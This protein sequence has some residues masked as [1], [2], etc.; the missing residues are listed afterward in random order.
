MFYKTMAEPI[1]ISLACHSP[2]LNSTLNSLGVRA[3]VIVYDKPEGVEI[4]SYM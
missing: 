4:G 1:D 3:V 2:Q